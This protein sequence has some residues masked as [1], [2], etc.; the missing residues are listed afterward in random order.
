M[1]GLYIGAFAGSP[2]G[3]YN[4]YSK[5]FSLFSSH[6]VEFFRPSSFS[7]ARRPVEEADNDYSSVTYEV[8]KTGYLEASEAVMGLLLD[9]HNQAFYENGEV[10]YKD[11][12]MTI[13]NVFRHLET[14]FGQDYKGRADLLLAA[15]TPLGAYPFEDPALDSFIKDYFSDEVTNGREPLPLDGLDSKLLG[16]FDSVAAY[17]SKD[18]TDKA[19]ID[20]ARAFVLSMSLAR[21]GHGLSDI[22]DFLGYYFPQID[23]SK[24][25]T[26]IRSE[27]NDKHYTE[28]HNLVIDFK[29][30][31]Y[32]VNRDVTRTVSCAVL[33]ALVG[34]GFEDSLKLAISMGG[35]T[36]LVALA[37]GAFADVVTASKGQCID[38]ALVG[39]AVDLAGREA[40]I[41]PFDELCRDSYK[42]QAVPV[43]ESLKS[44]LMEKFGAGNVKFSSSPSE[45]K[46]G[47]GAGFAYE[48]SEGT[49]QYEFKQK[50]RKAF[51]SRSG[52]V[53]YRDVYEVVTD[54]TVD[55]KKHTSQEQ[56]VC[57]YDS[58]RHPRIYVG[59]AGSPMADVL[60]ERYGE[61]SVVAREKNVFVYNYKNIPSE[62]FDVLTAGTSATVKQLT[63]DNRRLAKADPVTFFFVDAARVDIRQALSDRFGSNRVFTVEE[64]DDICR[65]Y[66]EKCKEMGV[67]SSDNY[68]FHPV[69]AELPKEFRLGAEVF[70]K[71]QK[72][73]LVDNVS[74]DYARMRREY[75]KP[76]TYLTVGNQPEMVYRYFNGEELVSS[77][78][79]EGDKEDMAYREK[80]RALF[81]ELKTVA[82]E[83]MDE[84][85]RRMFGQDL[86]KELF[87]NNSHLVFG[88]Y[89]NSLHPHDA[90]SAKYLEV[91][92]DSIRLM[93]GAY[94]I[95]S[96]SVSGVNGWLEVNKLVD[97]G[98]I[99]ELNPFVDLGA[100]KYAPDYFRQV[101]METVCDE[102]TQTLDEIEEERRKEEDS[103]GS[104]YEYYGR[105]SNIENANNVMARSQDPSISMELMTGIKD[106]IQKRK[107]GGKGETEVSREDSVQKPKRKSKSKK[108]S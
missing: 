51:R 10:V 90:K 13:E 40:D 27:A 83:V 50:R 28:D 35:D 59:D 16:A 55:D 1:I 78:Q 9:F 68:L 87:E 91:L 106:V 38:G 39:R 80:R 65:L 84:F 73:C 66:D 63:I 42:E 77:S 11:R 54:R 79:M 48:E 18:D 70:I 92:S 67:R 15:V 34:D 62:L 24:D 37:A 108:I 104:P 97:K 85:N 61:D 60:R 94:C 69:F 46:D 96:V 103:I 100:N 20:A 30:D 36:P 4:V 101:L 7:T 3:K 88:S 14:E 21:H 64:F 89:S 57:L 43:D 86:S 105:Q 23:L 52:K 22:D 102:F 26:T 6:T 81:T 2:Y 99:Y 45:K 58:G 25:I 47:E 19:V 56:V 31:S 75:F 74:L 107:S 41:L 32:K 17:F 98:E 82:L 71:E 29:K 12:P 49:R 33:A 95:G 76:D 8:E 72:A 44:A 53:Y 93:E 5:D